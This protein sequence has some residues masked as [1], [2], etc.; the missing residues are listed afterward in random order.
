MYMDIDKN[1]LDIEDALDRVQD[2]IELL[3]ELFDI[4]QEDFQVKLPQLK[5]ACQTANAEEIRNLAHSIKGAAGNISAREIQ[6]TCL[7]IE[8][9]GAEG[10]MNGLMPL[11]T[12]LDQQFKRFIEAA[13]IFRSQNR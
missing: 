2:D 4:F 13:D 10:D 7:A 1:V 5:A 12:G 9:K 6:Q 11:L 8:K 3:L